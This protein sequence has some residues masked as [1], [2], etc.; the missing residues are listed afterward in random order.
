M[1][2]KYSQILIEHGSDIDAP[3]LLGNTPLH[4]ASTY[5]RLPL[6]RLL[7][8]FGCQYDVKNNDGF[9]PADYSFS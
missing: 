5:G 8:D 6:I 7:I 2:M 1:L 9:T 4:N 3:D